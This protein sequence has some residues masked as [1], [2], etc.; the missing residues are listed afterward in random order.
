MRK[1]VCVLLCVGAVW[2]IASRAYDRTCQR[3]EAAFQQRLAELRQHSS[4][5]LKV[6][7]KRADVLSFLS[8]HGLQIVANDKAQVRAR[9]Y[10]S[11]GCDRGWGCSVGPDGAAIRLTV[12]FDETDAT[13]SEPVITGSYAGD[14]S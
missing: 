4:M 14:C 11:R 9:M 3:H 6:G 2:L 12:S 13:N 7:T 8:Q 1:L 5:A 10:T